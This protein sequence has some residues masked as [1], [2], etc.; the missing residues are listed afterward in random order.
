MRSALAA[1][2]LGWDVQGCHPG[3]EGTATVALLRLRCWPAL[4]PP[5]TCLTRFA[6]SVHPF[7]NIL[8]SPKNHSS[9]ERPKQGHKRRLH[10]DYL[11]LFEGAK[12]S[13][14]GPSVVH[15]LNAQGGGDQHA[16]AQ[17]QPVYTGGDVPGP[18]PARAPLP[19]RSPRRGSLVAGSRRGS[20][21]PAKVRQAERRCPRERACLVHVWSTRHRSPA[22]RNGRQRSPA[23]HRSPRSQAPSWGNEPMGRTLIR[24]RSQVQVLAGP[25]TNP[26]GHGHPR[27]SW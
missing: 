15:G 1:L 16:G 24:M 9:R 13:K 23:I 2:W 5:R 27:P 22:V 3:R 10:A 18:D 20:A 25:P 11:V 17:G 12:E 4:P 6:S 19:R 8:R 26:A 7:R 14:G 21:L